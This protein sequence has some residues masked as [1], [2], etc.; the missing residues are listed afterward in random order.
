MG[1]KVNPIGLR[2][3]IIRTWNSRWYARKNYASYL[4]EDL[5]I[6]NHIKTRLGHAG[7]SSV[8]IERSADQVRINVHT[9]KPGIIIGKKGAEVERIKKELQTLTDK[10]IYI[11]IIE[12]KSPEVEAQLIAESV[13]IQMERRIAFRRAMKRAVMGAMRLGAKGVRINC[14]GRLGGREMARTQRYLEGRVPLHTLRADI[15]YGFAVSR[16]TYGVIGV[17]VWIFKGEKL[18][19]GGRLEAVATGSVSRGESER[20]RKT[21]R[22][23]R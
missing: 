1:Q 5:R 19:R 14:A 6:R 23:T 22:K 15:D 9:A 18:T 2:L 3:G 10:Q 13:A 12:V 17:K 7:I 11:N 16:T 20:K 8:Q 4:H 21:D